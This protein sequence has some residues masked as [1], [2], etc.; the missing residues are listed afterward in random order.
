MSDSVSTCEANGDIA[1]SSFRS[2]TESAHGRQCSIL[3]REFA[4]YQINIQTLFRIETPRFKNPR[5]AN[6]V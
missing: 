1:R 5:W 3:M 2:A 6:R 4:A